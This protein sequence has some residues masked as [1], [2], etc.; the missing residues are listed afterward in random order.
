MIRRQ[1]TENK[2]RARKANS[3]S[4]LLSEWTGCKGKRK[5]SSKTNARSAAKRFAKK[6]GANTMRAYK[7]KHC[8]AWHLTKGK[9]RK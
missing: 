9:A 6:Y 4:Y 2:A 3:G 8:K 1:R 7:C 5:H